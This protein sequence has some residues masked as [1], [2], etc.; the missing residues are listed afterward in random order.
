MCFLHR[1]VGILAAL[2][3][4]LSQSLPRLVMILN[5]EGF[6]AGTVVHSLCKK[7]CI[8]AVTA[9]QRAGQAKERQDLH[10]KNVACSDCLL[11]HFRC[12]PF[13]Y[14]FIYLGH[15]CTSLSI[16]QWIR[17]PRLQKVYLF[18][19]F[20]IS[21]VWKNNTGVKGEEEILIHWKQWSI[22]LWGKTNRL[23]RSLPTK[24]Q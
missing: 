11:S 1:A 4:N 9:A 3:T 2:D 20:L 7:F 6:C 19:S 12:V 22:S 10:M 8:G 13:L 23:Y 24:T 14:I 21:A 18:S 15:E 17:N 5:P 16:R